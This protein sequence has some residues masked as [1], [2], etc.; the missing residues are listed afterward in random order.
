MSLFAIKSA[1]VNKKVCVS[2]EKW[3]NIQSLFEP[4][5]THHNKSKKKN[6][7]TLKST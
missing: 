1:N 3:I 6:V 5:K 7:E 4:Q 2:H